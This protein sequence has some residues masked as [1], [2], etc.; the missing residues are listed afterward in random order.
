MQCIPALLAHGMRKS[1]L[2][3]VVQARWIDSLGGHG[4]LLAAKPLHQKLVRNTTL[5]VRGRLM[6]SACGYNPCCTTVSEMVALL[7]NTLARLASTDHRSRVT[8]SRKVVVSY[9]G[10]FSTKP[11][12][13]VCSWPTRAEM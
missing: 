11:G 1:E 5:R 10:K 13:S 6:T 8:P 2:N 4:A 3:A 12:G 7:L 9:P